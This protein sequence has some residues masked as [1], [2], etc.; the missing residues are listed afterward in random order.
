M[1]QKNHSQLSP[2]HYSLCLPSDH[3]NQRSPSRQRKEYKVFQQLLKMVPHLRECLMETSDEECMMMADLVGV[4]VYPSVI[5]ITLCRPLKI[6]KGIVSARSDD[7][8]SLKGV[9]LDW[10]VP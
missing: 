9:V 7:A 3:L 4:S 6:Q 5:A 2:F 8:K 10:I 1:S